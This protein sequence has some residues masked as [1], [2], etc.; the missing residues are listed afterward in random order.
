MIG[1]IDLTVCGNSDPGTSGLLSPYGKIKGLSF[2]DSMEP[3]NF[4]FEFIKTI[5]EILKEDNVEYVDLLFDNQDDYYSMVNTLHEFNEDN[6][7]IRYVQR[8]KDY[9]QV[10]QEEEEDLVETLSFSVGSKKE[11]DKAKKEQKKKK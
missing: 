1:H 11:E 4:R 5:K 3:D 9:D 6:I 10:L 2:D 7:H 8:E